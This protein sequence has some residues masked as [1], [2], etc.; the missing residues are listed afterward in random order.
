MAAADFNLDGKDDLAY[1]FGSTLYILVSTGNGSFAAPTQYPVGS[2]TRYATVRDVNGD[3]KPDIIAA[4]QSSAAVYVLIGKGDGT[5]NNAVVV[6]LPGLPNRVAADDFNADGSVDLAVVRGSSTIG[7]VLLNR[8]SCSPTGAAVVTSAASYQRYTLA[9]ESIAAL[10][11]TGLAS[12]VQVATGVPLPTSLGGTSVRVKDS[13]GVERAAPLFFVSPNQ[14]NL[15]IPPGVAAG[16]AVLS[17]ISGSNTVAVGT[18]TISRLAPALFSADT[19]GQGFA[20]AVVLRVKADGT[21]I[22]EPVTA[23]N[24]TGQIVGV[25]IDLGSETDLVFLLLFG[26][27]IRGNSGLANVSATIGGTPIEV[28]Y[29]GAQGDFVGLDQL[30]LKL[31]RSLAGR[32]N[33]TIELTLDGKAANVVKVSIK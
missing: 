13:A 8:A 26:S 24:G 33:A 16:T 30:N 9:S 28:Q 6:P 7:T 21:Q 22:F 25:P 14:I 10:F 4:G 17:V 31:P 19:S 32:G 3:A 29:A 5:F 12:S 1:L 18:V 2:D 15:Q 23:S 11:G 20:S 27:G